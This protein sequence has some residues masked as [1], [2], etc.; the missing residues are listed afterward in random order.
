MDREMQQE[1]SRRLTPEEREIRVKKLKRKRNFRLAIVIIG[2]WLMISLIVVP[3]V[4]FAAFR[5]KTYNV[6]GVS[7]YSREEIIAACGIEQGKSLFF[8]D[9]DEAAEAIEKTLPYTD[10]V[11]L[12]K[13]LPSTLVIRYG[14]TAKSFAFDLGSDMYALTDSKLKVLELSAGIPE[15]VALVKG[16]V[17]LK[18]ETGEILSFMEKTTEEKKGEEPVDNTLSILLE[19]TG[20]IAEYGLEDINLVDVSS[21]SNIYMIYQERIVIQIGDSS[22]VSAK[23]S[24]GQRAIKE[25][26]TIDPSQFG[27]LNLTIV[28]KAYFNPSDPDDIEQLVKYKGGEWEE[29]EKPAE[30]ATVEDSTEEESENE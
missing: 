16:A 3:I 26:N 12:T 17:P 9:L 14:E 21:R 24:L 30:S 4:L 18:P 25:E 7:P 1:Q 19:I 10:D 6:E 28:K 2:F 5:V 29:P 11:V 23:L 27:T 20:A 8:A 15:G 22:D 13:K